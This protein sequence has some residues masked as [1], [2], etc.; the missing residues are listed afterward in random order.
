MKKQWIFFFIGSLLSFN[1]QASLFEANV[2]MVNFP[3]EQEKKI[4]KAIQLI[5]KVVTS[6]EFKERIISHAINGK[7]TFMDNNGFTNEEIYQKI[8]EGGCFP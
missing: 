7:K 8:I 3:K 6:D 5:K 1:L 2:Q 4:I